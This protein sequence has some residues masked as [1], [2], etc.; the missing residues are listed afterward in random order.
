MGFPQPD[1]ITWLFESDSHLASKYKRLAVDHS[2]KRDQQNAIEKHDGDYG[3][4]YKGLSESR[5]GL[6]HTQVYLDLLC[7][8]ESL[9]WQIDDAKGHDVP[10]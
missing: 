8:L 3:V 7:W 6:Y 2:H 9:E 4:Q 10:R 1:L 5:A